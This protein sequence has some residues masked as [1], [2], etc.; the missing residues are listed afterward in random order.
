MISILKELAIFSPFILSLFS[1]IAL[2]LKYR[3]QDKAKFIL[4]IFML[5]GSLFYTISILQSFNHLK[6]YSYFFTLQITSLMLACPQVYFY[7]R[8]LTVGDV[9]IRKLLW[10]FVPA[11]IMLIIGSLL[12]FQLNLQERVEFITGTQKDSIY[13]NLLR[14][15]FNSFRFIFVG[16]L[17]FYYIV[18]WRLISKY[19]HELNQI[20]SDISGYGLNWAR[21]FLG[22]MFIWGTLGNHYFLGINQIKILDEYS[23]VFDLMIS[24]LICALYL[25]GSIQKSISNFRINRP[26]TV[27]EENN[28]TIYQKLKEKL[29]NSIESKEIFL[30]KDL[31]IWD[32]CREVNSNRTY[33]SNLI[34]E[35]FGMNFN[36]F[37][38]KYRIN[39]AKSLL[40]DKNYQNYS[41][42]KIAELSGFNSLASFNRAFQK[43]ENISPGQY[44]NMK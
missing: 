31:T 17:I 8:E 12:Y 15:F 28:K 35:E 6:G 1:F 20:F 5:A 19:Q 29:L 33:I 3:N 27:K 38:N 44:R 32:L 41:L 25:F 9:K 14:V 7:I 22:I 24:V 39:K 30:R 36:S 2:F 21:Y 23:F 13:T 10:H 16:Q 43:F 18:T 42:G 4:S 40:S 26:E 34:N 11:A 37:V